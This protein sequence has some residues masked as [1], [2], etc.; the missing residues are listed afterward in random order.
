MQARLITVMYF[1]HHHVGLSAPQA[2]SP[3]FFSLFLVTFFCFAPLQTV[4]AVP[5]LAHAILLTFER[6]RILPAIAGKVAQSRWKA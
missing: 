6:D 2:S 1:K 5:A 3:V 4:F